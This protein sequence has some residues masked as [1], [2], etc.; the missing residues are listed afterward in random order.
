MRKYDARRVAF[1]TLL[2]TDRGSFADSALGERLER[3]ELDRR[4][5]DLATL[6][7]YGTLAR[8]LTLDYTIAG[9]AG[10][11]LDRIEPGLLTLLRLG[12]FQLGFCDRMPAY[13]VLD[14]TVSLADGKLRRGAGFVNAVLRRTTREGLRAADGIAALQR[15]RTDDEAPGEQGDDID[16]TRDWAQ[17]SPDRR[18]AVAFS[19]P[20]WLVRLWTS[21]LGESPANAFM[22]ANNEAAPNVLRVLV[23]RAEAIDR[24]RDMGLRVREAAH[25]PDAVLASGPERIPGLALPQGEASQLVVR[26]LNPGRG[27]AVLDACAAPGGKTAYIAAL[28]GENGRVVAVDNGRGARRRIETTL[29]LAGFTNGNLPEI[30]VLDEDFLRSEDRDLGAPLDAALVDAPCSGLGTLRQHPEIRWRRTARDLAELATRQARLLERAAGAVRP[31][32]RLVYSTC[33][34]VRAE[35]ED[36]VD[37]F[38]AAHP[39]YEADPSAPG[40]DAAGRLHTFPHEG[41][42]DGFFAAALRRKG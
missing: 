17:L 21:E 35:N 26:L 18:R 41:G 24:L 5:R 7:V 10:R 29:R 12:L 1:E 33:T 37:G 27:E 4:E 31:G 8:R 42:M 39:D 11:P 9:Y 20:L 6:L 25:A 36:I 2:E 19:H 30:R 34:V 23:P 3:I 22:Q 16:L 38:L 28:V 40:A 32:G 14:R 15:G 13:A